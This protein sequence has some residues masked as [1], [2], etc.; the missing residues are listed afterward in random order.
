MSNITKDSK[1]SKDPKDIAKK[2]REKY[3]GRIPV[4]IKDKCKLDITKKKYIVPEDI[5]ISQFLHFLRKYIN[6]IKPDQA[7]F[8]FIN[9]KIPTMSSLISDSDYVSNDGFVY[10]DLSLESTFG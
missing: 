10:I 2:I 7:L 4:L 3:P 5:T 9:N 6:K 1:D 8:I